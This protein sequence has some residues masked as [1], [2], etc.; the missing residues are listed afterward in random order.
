[1]CETKMIARAQCLLH[2]SAQKKKTKRSKSCAPHQKVQQNRMTDSMK[3]A[4][5]MK[6]EDERRK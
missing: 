3:K 2:I 5:S 6:E 4:V 1:M